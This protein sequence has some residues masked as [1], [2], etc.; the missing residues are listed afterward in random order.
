MNYRLVRFNDGR[1][2]VRKEGLF[3]KT[4]VDLEDPVYSWKPVENKFPSCKGSEARAR[5]VLALV[6]RP[7]WEYV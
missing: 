5:E 7:V 3:L 1:Y 4:F 2:G 6:H